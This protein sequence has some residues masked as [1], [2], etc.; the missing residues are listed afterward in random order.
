M[1]I[2]PGGA[3][4]LLRDT[5]E[6]DRWSGPLEADRDIEAETEPESEPE[7]LDAPG[8]GPF[9]TIVLELSAVYH[10]EGEGDVCSA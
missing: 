2:R 1:T 7:P 8:C 5:L 3:C 10:D 6:V 9:V 4:T